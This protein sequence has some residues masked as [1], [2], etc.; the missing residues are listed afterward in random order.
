ML[1]FAPHNSPLTELGWLP[2]DFLDVESFGKSGTA[3]SGAGRIKG[4]AST[5]MVDSDGH[6]VE[7]DGIDWTL[8]KAAGCP[9]TF[10]HPRSPFNDIGEAR[11][12][13]RVTV[14]G[15]NAT[16]I[17]GI[18][19]T[20][21][22]LGNVAYGRAVAMAKAGSKR[23]MGLSIEGY[24]T[25]RDGNRIQKSVVTSVAISDSP[26]NALTWFDPIMASRGAFGLPYALQLS[27]AAVGYPTQGQPSTGEIAPMVPQSLQGKA[28]TGATLSRRDLLV[29]RLMQ[30]QPGLSYRDACEHIDSASKAA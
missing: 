7:Q 9:L 26:K 17:S 10:E 24:A 11:D 15:V 6:V 18:V 2:V 21:L 22:P 5:E 4:I 1:H 20:T 19:Y 16:A 29:W 30:R 27:A 23:R 28:D 14:D 3:G 8:F 13:E 25:Q 12:I